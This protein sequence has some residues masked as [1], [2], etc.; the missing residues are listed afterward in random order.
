MSSLVFYHTIAT[1]IIIIKYISIMIN[2]EDTSTTV[3]DRMIRIQRAIQI[4]NGEKPFS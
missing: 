4:T 1:M 3:I 2:G